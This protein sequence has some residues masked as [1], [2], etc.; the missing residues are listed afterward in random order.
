MHPTALT[1]AADAAGD[2]G[3]LQVSGSLKAGDVGLGDKAIGFFDGERHLGSVLTDRE[4]RFTWRGDASGARSDAPQELALQARFESDAPWLGSSHSETQYLQLASESGPSPLL[5]LLPCVGCLWLLWWLDRAA[6]ARR[7]QSAQAE[8]DGEAPTVGVHAAPPRRLRP[9]HWNVAGEIRDATRRRAIQNA[10]VEL[11]P[12]GGGDLLSVQPDAR[13]RFDSGALKAG[14][15]TVRVLAPGYAPSASRF[16][17]PHRGEWSAASVRLESLRDAAVRAF[18]P[19]ARAVLPAGTPIGQTTAREVWQRAFRLG[20]GGE[21]LRELT[22][23]VDRA[24]YGPQ[25]PTLDDVERIAHDAGQTG[26]QL[27][28]TDRDDPRA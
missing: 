20:R 11:I 16:T 8:D 19:A 17:V 18:E 10:T 26:G 3:S 15:W 25:P 13:G 7:R 1:L 2:A 12:D 21:P 22:A 9:T 6:S 4:G 27:D 23:R 24:A 28:G 5:L 14:A